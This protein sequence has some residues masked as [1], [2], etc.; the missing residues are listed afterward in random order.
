MTDERRKARKNN[1]THITSFDKKYL[2]YNRD[3]HLLCFKK[4][5]EENAVLKMFFYL[6]SFFNIF[7]FSAI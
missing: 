6:L 3:A 5:K 2:A 1:I 7:P 4:R